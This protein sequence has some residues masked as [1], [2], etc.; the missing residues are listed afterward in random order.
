MLALA[1]RHGLLGMLPDDPRLDRA[2]TAARS[3]AVARYVRALADLAVVR[4]AVDATGG[5]WVA[6][7]GPAVA[8]G[9]YPRPDLRPFSDIDVLVEPARFGPVLA[10]LEARGGRCLV[11]NWP[12]MTELG[13]AELPVLLPAG[14]VLD[15]HWHVVHRA[16]ARRSWRLDTARLLERTVPVPGLD[17]IQTLEPAATLV[18]LAWHS[19]KSG[20]SRLLWACDV[21]L[22]AARLPDTETA[23]LR[24]LCRQTRTT[25]AV[26]SWLP[27]KSASMPQC[28]PRT[29]P[30]RSTASCAR[31]EPSLLAS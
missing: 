23:E 26:P 12:R 22:A 29:P 18:H 10:E 9:L 3:A 6:L 31:R 13:L 20:G 15:L 21:E 27:P 17:G 2:R 4:E 8:A 28:P 1:E 7:K 11:H 30:P 5:R 14:S 24:A 16:R 19:T 25:L